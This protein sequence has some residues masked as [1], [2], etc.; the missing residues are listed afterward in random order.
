MLWR[1][2][3]TRAAGQA[4]LLVIQTRQ[5]L[6]RGASALALDTLLLTEALNPDRL[7]TYL[8]H[9]ELALVRGQ[10]EL[11]EALL[12]RLERLAS[13][14][15]GAVDPI[16]LRRL[17]LHLHCSLDEL[18][19]FAREILVSG[20][21]DLW[22]TYL[23]P[24]LASLQAAG[25]V[26][27]ALELARS[28]H[29]TSG[30]SA[31]AWWAYARQ[32]LEAREVNQARELLT[33]LPRMPVDSYQWAI[34]LGLSSLASEQHELRLLRQAVDDVRARRVAATDL[35]RELAALSGSGA[36]S[37]PV[38]LYRALLW[39][40]SGEPT[41]AFELASSV[42]AS[43]TLETRVLGH[44]VAAW[45]ALAGPTPT[46]ALPY[47]QAAFRLLATSKGLADDLAELLSPPVNALT[48][49]T[50]LASLLQQHGQLEEA[51]D[52]LQR[53]VELDPER[54]ELRYRLAELMAQA[55]R[56][57][58]A[59]QL[60]QSFAQEQQARRD[61]RGRL[62]TLRH[63]VQLTPEGPTVLEELITGYTRIGMLDQAIAL[64]E[65][66]AA[67][68]AASRRVDSAVELLRRAAELAMLGQQWNVI[69]RL[70]EQLIS[71]DPDN[72]DHRHA[73]VTA[74]VQTGQLRHAVEQLREIARIA[75]ARGEPEEALAALHQVVALDARNP[76]AYHRLAEVLV[77]LG[78]LAQAE[79]VYRR[80]LAVHPDD[81]VAR[82][83][84]AALSGLL[85]PEDN[86][87][88]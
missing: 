40:A 31:T 54:A 72:L 67:S 7:E 84:Q 51:I 49:G 86:A 56:V 9:T 39:L 59:R 38:E 4:D 21:S 11:A 28:W 47:L 79:R 1:Q 71:L 87:A 29:M 34:L 43:E 57:E 14:R 76:D 74:Y 82:A 35:D 58:Q 73:A 2:A 23:P 26:A 66:L 41:R 16:D 19:A 17:R 70:Y 80:L 27:E 24:I 52:V 65:Q 5:A 60:L 42:N 64:L 37:R 85:R 62:E 46:Q 44:A 33:A 61:F 3:S 36:W 18:L 22:A 78:E 8:T 13:L 48:V 6:A 15:P 53:L 45:A 77:S 81:Q 55:R 50:Q 30:A 10:R 75:L 83:K 12:T 25:S 32:V 63:L 20:R 69:P 68:A 88:R